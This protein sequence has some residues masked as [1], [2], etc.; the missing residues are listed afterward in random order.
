MKK[1]FVVVFTAIGMCVTLL[2]ACGKPSVEGK[3][4]VCGV[5]IEGE[6]VIF[7]DAEDAIQEIAENEDMEEE[8]VE[9][10]VEEAE[11]ECK[12]AAIGFAEDGVCILYDGDDEEEGEWEEED[13]K[14]IITMEDDTEMEG[15][16]EDDLLCIELD[17]PGSPKYYFEKTDD[18]VEIK[19]KDEEEEETEAP[20]EEP[21]EATEAPTEEPIA[22][23]T[24]KPIEE[25]V[26][27]VNT[28]LV[29][30]WIPYAMDYSGE[31]WTFDGLR[32]ELIQQYID[33]GMD[34]KT[35]IE[36]TDTALDSAFEIFEGISFQFNEDGT[37]DA[38]AMGEEAS[39][40][41]E[42]TTTGID[43][44]IDGSTQAFGYDGTEISMESNGQ[45]VYFTKE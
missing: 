2:S 22:E 21:L 36:T 25:P 33:S 41:W 9:E 8:E 1:N 31:K 16:I 3:W 29:G 5:E 26:A 18:E 43:V 14:I 4:E 32:E 13:D 6:K 10:M 44:T 40:T 38:V 15:E 7:D 37:V 28:E 27:D 30:K 42:E 12:D 20:T 45:T 24:E 11:D 39:G 17:I 35:A 23:E 34:E 19:D